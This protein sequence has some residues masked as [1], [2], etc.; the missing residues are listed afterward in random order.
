MDVIGYHF[1][2]FP[3]PPEAMLPL[4]DKVKQ[5]LKDNG[6][7]KQPIWDT[8]LGWAEPKP[9]SSGELAASYLAR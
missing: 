6:A 4:I 8:E 9:F 1:Y 5:T 2:V 3:Q 7:G